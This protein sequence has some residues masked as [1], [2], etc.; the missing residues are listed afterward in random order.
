MALCMLGEMVH[1]SAP[2]KQNG[3]ASTVLIC[4]EYVS[5]IAVCF[6]ALI[7]FYRISFKT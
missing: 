1:C 4:V 6:P 3:S 2:R 7:A 5:G